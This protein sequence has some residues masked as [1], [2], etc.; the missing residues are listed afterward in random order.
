MAEENLNWST[1][2]A[3][4]TQTILTAKEFLDKELAKYD[5]WEAFRSGETSRAIL[6]IKTGQEFSALKKN[7][8]GRDTLVKFL[9]GNWTNFHFAIDNFC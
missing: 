6:G 4:M 3:V 5:T 1:S 8:V 7:G 2:P 9:G